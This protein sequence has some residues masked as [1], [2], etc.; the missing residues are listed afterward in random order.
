MLAARDEQVAIGQYAAEE[1]H[2]E[3]KDKTDDDLVP[4]GPA[5]KIFIWLLI[6][7]FLGGVLYQAL[8]TDNLSPF[9]TG[10]LNSISS[11]LIPVLISALLVFGYF[12]GVKI[13]ET[14]TDGAKDQSHQS[15]H[16]QRPPYPPDERT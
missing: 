14:L 8:Q 10:A 11:W 5:G 13:Y 12:R 2:S 4:P 16:Q 6:A 1:F 9:S 3:K 7:A 15:S